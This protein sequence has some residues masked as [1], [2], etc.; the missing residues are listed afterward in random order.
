M[1]KGIDA[2]TQQNN[3]MFDQDSL[4][5]KIAESIDEWLYFDF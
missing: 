4:K 5:V 1:N 2:R 3:M